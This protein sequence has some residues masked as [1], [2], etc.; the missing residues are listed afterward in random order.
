MNMYIMDSHP[1][2]GYIH[3]TNI[4]LNHGHTPKSWIHSQ[5]MDT[6]PKSWKHHPNHGNITQIM[7]TS[8]NSWKHHLNH[9][10]ITQ[11]MDTHKIPDTHVSWTLSKSWIQKPKS[12]T[13]PQTMDTHQKP[14]THTPQ[15]MNT[16][17]HHGYPP[18]P[19]HGQ[20]YPQIMGTHPIQGHG[21]TRTHCSKNEH[22]YTMNTHKSRTNRHQLM[23]T[24]TH[25]Y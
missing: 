1:K 8:P 16:L 20:K 15:M 21:H 22:I 13:D 5:I 2:Y 6:S 7:E 19:N 3:P 9:G 10:H 11:I 17:F 23:D 24:D 4:P 18:L 25:T 12:W 14:Q